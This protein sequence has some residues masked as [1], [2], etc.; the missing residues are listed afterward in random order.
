MTGLPVPGVAEYKKQ[1]QTLKQNEKHKTHGQNARKR[2][3][4]ALY[5]LLFFSNSKCDAEQVTDDDSVSLGT[6]I[7]CP[8]AEHEI[9][10]AFL[11]L[12]AV[13][14]CVWVF[15][16]WAFLPFRLCFQEPSLNSSRLQKENVRG[17]FAVEAKP[18]KN[19]CRSTPGAP[20]VLQ[21]PFFSSTSPTPT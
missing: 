11:L 12:T 8:L 9:A 3:L 4:Q 10:F 5:F 20:Q 2:M 21:Q 14:R 1:K 6:R 15:V 7:T 13:L 18:K 17:L 16:S 19:K